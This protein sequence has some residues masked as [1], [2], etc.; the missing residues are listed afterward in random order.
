MKFLKTVRKYFSEFKFIKVSM[1]VAFIHTRKINKF[2]WIVLKTTI[3][4]LKSQRISYSFHSPF[5]FLKNSLFRLLPHNLPIKIFYQH[6]FCWKEN[7]VERVRGKRRCRLHKFVLGKFE[8]WIEDEE[9]ESKKGKEI[10][11]INL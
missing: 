1:I 3:K 10:D 4:M 2:S 7:Y 9:K 6:I 8:E 5:E 11:G